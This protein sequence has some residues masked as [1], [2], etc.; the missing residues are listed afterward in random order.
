MPTTCVH[1]SLARDTFLQWS[2]PRRRP[3]FPPSTPTH[4]FRIPWPSLAQATFLTFHLQAPGLARIRIASRSATIAKTTREALEEIIPLRPLC[5]MA[6]L[7][8]LPRTIPR[9]ILTR[10]HT[11][12]RPSTLRRI[13][14]ALCLDR[15][16]MKSSR[17][18][19]WVQ[20]LLPRLPNGWC[21]PT[22]PPRAPRR[23]REARHSS[24]NIYKTL[25]RPR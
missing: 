15:R 23:A 11:R 2:A 16:A 5:T 21:L 10:E 4:L 14:V 13:R 24:R 6:A 12:A 25:L 3:V 1:P 9:D 18:H 20:A 8:L 19:E 7:F 17:R 22:Y